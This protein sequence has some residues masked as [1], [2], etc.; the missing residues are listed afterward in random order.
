MKNLPVFG[1]F[2][3][4]KMNI[5]LQWMTIENQSISPTVNLFLRIILTACINS[6]T[7]VWVFR[8]FLRLLWPRHRVKFLEYPHC[9]LRYLFRHS[10][11]YY[12]KE[13]VKRF[14][15][16]SKWEYVKRFDHESKWE[17]ISNKEIDKH[18]YLVIYW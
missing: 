14:D 13:Y 7:S 6:T 9:F 11:V 16:E 2:L 18:I 5:F 12:L 15:N 1:G 10:M 3:R 8:A 4:P 17:Y